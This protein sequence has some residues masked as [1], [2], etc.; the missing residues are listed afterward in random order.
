MTIR[1]PKN[2]YIGPFRVR[3]IPIHVHWTF[4][5]GGLFVAFF[6]GNVS[7]KTAI[8]LVVAYTTLILVHELGHAFGARIASSKVHAVLV[9]AAGGWCFADEPDSFWSRF[10][11]YAGGIAAQILVLLI[12]A[13]L[14]ALFG[15]PNSL[16]LNSF[17]LVFTVVNVILIIINIIPTEGTDGQKLWGLLKERLNAA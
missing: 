16:V 9:T 14:V 2:G 5:V 1:I 3:D 15:N 11:F 17:V 13:I 6:L 7:W 4:P 12:T 8:P 10:A